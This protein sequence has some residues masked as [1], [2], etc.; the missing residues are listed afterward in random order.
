MSAQPQRRRV[1]SSQ[2][3]PGAA[4]EQHAAPAASVERLRRGSRLD[5]I[6]EILVDALEREEERS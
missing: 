2:T 4:T 5:R 3:L 6:A 1:P